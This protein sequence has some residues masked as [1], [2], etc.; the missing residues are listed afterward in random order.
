MTLGPLINSMPGWSTP[1]VCDGIGIEHFGLRFP[2]PAGRPCLPLIPCCG[3]PPTAGRD[4]HRDQRRE[5]GRSVAFD[6]ADAELMLEGL[7]QI[8]R[9]FLGPGR[10]PRRAGSNAPS[11]SVSDSRARN[12]GVESMIVTLCSSHSLPTARLERAEV[13]GRLYVERQR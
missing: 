10:R 11:R 9:Q 12:V 2:E 1:E 5:F 7:A 3:G 6:R 8:D 4:I 13:V